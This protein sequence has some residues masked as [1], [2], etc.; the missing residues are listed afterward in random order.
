MNGATAEPC[1]STIS[2]PKMTIIT[3]IGRSQNFLRA[4][5]NCQSSFKNDVLFLG[6]HQNC[7][8]IVSG[9]GPGGVLSIQ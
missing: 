3:R 5:R 1:V 7:C 2:P 8:D 9:G 4:R 6:Y